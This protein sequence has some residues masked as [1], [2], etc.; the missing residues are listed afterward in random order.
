[1]SVE[2]TLKKQAKEILAKE[3]W[4]KSIMGFL[5]VL[6]VC[7][8]TFL[9]VDL[10]TY[11]ITDDIF[12]KPIYIA[13]MIGI[14]LVGIIAFI[15]LS[16]FYTGYIKFIADSK[17]QKTGD[18]QN[19][20]Y[21]F[22]KKRYLDT[23]QLNLSLFVRYAVLFIVCALPLALF[24]VLM[25]IMPDYET[26]FKIGALWSGII[27][28]VVLFIVS[29]FYVMVQYLYV[30]DFDYRKEKEII[31]A[32]RYMVKKNFGKIMN[33]Y[34]SFIVYWLLS[35]FMIPVVFVYPYF[36]HTAVLSYSYI[37]ELEKSNFVSSYSQFNNRLDEQSKSDCEQL[38]ADDYVEQHNTQQVDMDVQLQV[39]ENVQ[40]FNT[41]NSNQFG[42]HSEIVE[43]NQQIKTSDKINS[44]INNNNINEMVSNFNNNQQ[45]TQNSFIPDENSDI[46][47]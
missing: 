20:I 45:T 18:V 26:G 34:I 38:G 44:Q 8:I 16:P 27:G 33:L 13:I 35:F 39:Q 10:S 9:I 5:C 6:S 31:K 40:T 4:A 12:S 29:R 36:K 15:M 14:A 47:M 22:E 41:Q 42:I 3:N 1:M 46:I 21:Y 43:N 7:G 32:S 30:S 17:N 37:Y 19:F 28:V 23:V 11:F 25:N 2:A 24:L